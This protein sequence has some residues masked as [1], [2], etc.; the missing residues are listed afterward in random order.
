MTDADRDCAYLRLVFNEIAENQDA[1]RRNPM[2][3]WARLYEA[4]R[5]TCSGLAVLQVIADRE[6]EI[7]RLQREVD[8]LNGLVPRPVNLEVKA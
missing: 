6:A 4:A 2:A 3:C 5:D 7:E 1:W 8:R